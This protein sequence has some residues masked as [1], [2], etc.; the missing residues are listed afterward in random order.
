MS[1]IAILPV[2]SFEAAKQ[3]LSTGLAAGPREILAQAMSRDVLAALGTV[4][5]IDEV[6]VVTADPLAATTARAAGATVLHDGREAGQSAAAALG[7]ERALGR[8]HAR[9]LLVPG[10]TPL[11]DGRELTGMLDRAQARAT[12]VSIVP[13]RH[14]VGTNALLLDPPDAIAPAFGP[15]SLERHLAAARA[16]G[17]S[18]GVEELAGLMLDIDT[19]EDLTAL[20]ARLAEDGMG[21]ANT[22]AALEGLGR[23]LGTGPRT[24]ARS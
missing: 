19:P 18:H 7:I 10:D 11:L 20:S 4:A 14:R 1:T 9:V 5:G 17:V 16:A 12:A 23:T 22:R 21:A 6:V 15:R 24:G 3:R 13:D 2:K 8:G